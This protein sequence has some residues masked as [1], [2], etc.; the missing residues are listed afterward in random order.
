MEVGDDIPKRLPN[1]PKFDDFSQNGRSKSSRNQLK[2][3][4]ETKMEAQGDPAAPKSP[5]LTPSDA[6][7]FPKVIQS[8]PKTPKVIQK[9]PNMRPKVP[10]HCQKSRKNGARIQNDF[11]EHI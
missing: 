2:S 5:N 1:S 7:S 11:G 8:H 4:S 6:Q 3:I 9:T 10:Q